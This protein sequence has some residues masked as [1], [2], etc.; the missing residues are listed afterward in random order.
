MISGPPLRAPGPRARAPGSRVA[1][2]EQRGPRPHGMVG[3]R[4]LVPRNGHSQYRN[5][6][7][8]DGNI[9]VKNGSIMVS[10]GIFWWEYGGFHSHKGTPK[11]MVYNGK[12]YENGW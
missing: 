8:N 2:G 12:S 6:M 3:G 1:Q 9:V 5:M 11:W 7:V 10:D 4:E